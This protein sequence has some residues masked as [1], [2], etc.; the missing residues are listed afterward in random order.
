MS[1]ADYITIAKRIIETVSNNKSFKMP[2]MQAKDFHGV[3]LA[4][5]SLQAA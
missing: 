1:K 5:S 2:L 3:M 4:M